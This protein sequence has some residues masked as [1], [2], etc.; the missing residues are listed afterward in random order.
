MTARD[1]VQAAMAPEPSK[2]APVRL[3]A[4]HVRTEPDEVAGFS[5]ETGAI[6][7]GDFVPLTFPFRWLTLPAIRAAILQSIG[8]E[9]FLPVH[10]GQS[11]AYERSLRIGTDYVLA[12]DIRSSEKP[13]RLMVTMAVSTLDGK[14]CARLE[15]ILR[16]VRLTQETPS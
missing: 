3:A 13:P 8:G 15:T 11:F 7:T 2:A 14:I 10:E 16:I 1:Q 12:V 9:G 6:G 5:R 4:L